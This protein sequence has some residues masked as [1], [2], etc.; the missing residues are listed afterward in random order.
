MNALS[1]KIHADLDGYLSDPLM[2]RV[3][4][5]IYDTICEINA[6]YKA[7]NRPYPVW[8]PAHVIFREAYSLMNDFIN[9]PHPEE[10]F[11][12]TYFNKVRKHL[13]DTYAAEIVLSVD[14]TLL[15]LRDDK[16]SRLLISSIENTV[17]VNS[18]YFK[19]FERLADEL[20]GPVVDW[21]A[22]YFALQRQYDALYASIPPPMV[23]R[24]NQLFIP[25]DSLEA[26]RQGY[27]SIEDLLR[28]ADKNET[29]NIY[30]VLR[31]LLDDINHDFL[32]MVMAA[33]AMANE[34]EASRY[35]SNITISKNFTKIDCIRVIISLF[36]KGKFKTRDG[37]QL[38]QKVLF[39]DFGNFLGVD[40]SNG[41]TE[42][43][44]ALSDNNKLSKN[45]AIF[46][47]MS[48]AVTEDFNSK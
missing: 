27:V 44:N 33:E 35:T 1:F 25:F 41:P 3:N 10:Y 5:R 47:V 17:D 18:A 42:Y 36:K 28:V 39:E 26:A 7:T 37:S 29:L 22:K 11:A 30:F 34:R 40:L 23:D 2:G 12:E 6:P 43:N 48:S 8:Q 32:D 31:L 45:I 13:L 20:S 4:E 38:T 16:K 14:F 46:E 9:E 19:A 15:R 21:K 24:K